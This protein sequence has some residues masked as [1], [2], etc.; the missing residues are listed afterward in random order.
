M[1]CMYI[2]ERV[3]GRAVVAL[4]IDAQS[5]IRVEEIPEADRRLGLDQLPVR[6]NH[7][8]ENAQFCA[9]VKAPSSLSMIYR[10][11]DVKPL[12]L[13]TRQTDYPNGSVELTH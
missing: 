8:N 4:Y 13:C 9:T 7:T 11:L 1:V 12:T 2:V 10:F 3:T 5:G 6:S